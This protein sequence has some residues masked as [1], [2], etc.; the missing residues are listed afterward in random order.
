MRS[1]PAAASRIDR[2][3]GSDGRVA[4][5]APSPS[6]GDDGQ[7]GAGRP[8]GEPRRG[9]EAAMD[10]PRHGEATNVEDLGARVLR[11]LGGVPDLS[12]VVLF[13]SRAGGRPRPESDL[14]VAILPVSR[15]DVS[16]RKLQARVAAALADL[17]ADGRV[18][19]V[20]LDE[21]PELLRQRIMERGRVLLDRE[22]E[23]WRELRRRT[24]REHGDREP[25][26]NLL[27]LA[28]MRRLLAGAEDGRS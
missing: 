13:G 14:D 18:D 16:R 1:P 19:V 25:Y 23:R 27:R 9:R 11:A 5:R 28:Q 6:N 2:P 8:H 7:D 17:A 15:T 20:F 24:M 21:A 10:H 26:R 4:R 22:P 3:R 12:T